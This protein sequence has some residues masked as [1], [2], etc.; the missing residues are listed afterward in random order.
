[1]DFKTA[2]LSNG[3]K[4]IMNKNPKQTTVTIAVLVNTG[5]NWETPNEMLLVRE[6]LNKKTS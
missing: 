5:S 3:L 1:M 6:S 4:I 2:Q